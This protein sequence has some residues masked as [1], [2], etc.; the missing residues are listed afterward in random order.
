[1]NFSAYIGQ[2]MPHNAA[3]N[4]RKDALFEG[5]SLRPVGVL[6]N[7]LVLFAGF[8]SD[9]AR[10]VAEVG[11]DISAEVGNIG[12]PELHGDFLNRRSYSLSLTFT[13]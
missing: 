13:I 3:K 12:E 1:M 4:G 5:E 9:K 11:F 6:Y 7:K 2:N 8:G 10:G